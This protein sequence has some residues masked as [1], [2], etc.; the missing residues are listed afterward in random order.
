MEEDGKREGRKVGAARTYDFFFIII[1]GG[2][3]SRDIGTNQWLIFFFLDERGERRGY[4][5]DE[6]SGFLQ[7]EQ[8]ARDVFVQAHGGSVK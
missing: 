2:R 4:P 7:W 8:T 3:S 1:F 5:K 6:G